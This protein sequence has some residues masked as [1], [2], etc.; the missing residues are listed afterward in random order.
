MWVALSATFGCYHAVPPEGAPCGSDSD[1]P[2]PQTCVAGACSLGGI[3]IDA[4]VED[5]LAIDAFDLCTCNAGTQT[6][7]LSGQTQCELGCSA[8][9]PRCAIVLPSNGIPTSDLDGAT[10]D[11]VVSGVSLTTFD[12][13]TGQISG[14]ITRAAGS[15]VINGI[16]YY[17]HT[18]SVGSNTLAEFSMKSLSVTGTAQFT[19][20]H[21]VVFLVATDVTIAGTIDVSGGSYGKDQRVAGPGAGTG[22]LGA[23]PAAG[24]GAGGTG[25]SDVGTGADTGG[26]G[27]GYGGAGAAG[28]IETASTTMFAGGVAGVACVSIGLEPLLGGSGGGGGG[29]GGGTALPGGGGGGALQISALGTISVSGTINAGGAGGSP[30]PTNASN[31]GAGGGGGSGGGIL[32]EAITVGITGVLAANGG[33]G[34]GSSDHS[35]T[36]TVGS[37]GF[38]GAAPAQPGTP[39]GS[40]A[41]S[42]S[43]GSRSSA[44]G[45]GGNSTDVNSGAGGGGV[46]AIFVRSTHPA[47]PPGG[48]ISPAP[49][50]AMV[51]SQ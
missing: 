23:T 41:A 46:G 30:G 3:A 40:A 29:P 21:S 15:G 35:T 4:R 37:N 20:S 13:N 9:G 12:V 17:Q 10:M 2:S 8:N 45:V 28:G 44:P 26:G 7:S 22:G 31:A 50:V 38:A 49:G 32:L 33:G 48:T 11:V 36:G 51:R 16:G 18:D 39:G 24:C 43:G 42:G 6:C 34:G 25:A 14:G 47:S 27:G 1:C 19:G 5:S